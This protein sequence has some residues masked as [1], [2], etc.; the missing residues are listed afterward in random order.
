MDEFKTTISQIDEENATH[1]T[2][3]MEPLERGFGTTVGNSLRRIMLSGLS[4]CAVTSVLIHGALHEFG[5]IEGV[6]EDITE[7]ILNV[8]G[9]VAKFCGEK[10]E[11]KTLHL[12]VK[13]SEPRRIVTAGDI[14]KDADIEIINPDQPLCTLA[15]GVSF[16]MDLTFECGRGY[17]SGDKNKQ[18][19][20]SRGFD[21]TTETNDIR[22][23][24]T[25]SIYSPVL[26]VAYTVES[27]RVGSETDL[28]KLTIEVTT[29]GSLT[30]KDAMSL[31]ASLMVRKLRDV[32]ALSPI[33]ENG[34]GDSDDGEEHKDTSVDDIVF[35]VRVR[36][37]LMRAGI[38]TLEELA[39]HTEREIA[40]LRGLGKT[41]VD[42]M[43]TRLE[44][45]GLA[46]RENVD[47]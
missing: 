17:V 21:A 2:F 36:N 43:R 22:T 29:N 40:G 44:E 15:Y 30:P 10:P 3:V 31:A 16:T 32:V 8:K 1:G 45:H 24:F 38:K 23:I 6:R 11:P 18:I 46:F 9:I 41:S 42:E 26:N 14:A 35:S 28:D 5:T 27:T 37:G 25:D 33:G 19:A 4:G 39:S 34:F 20:A 13:S 7:I 47:E 12:D